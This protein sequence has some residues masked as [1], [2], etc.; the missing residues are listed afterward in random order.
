M[1]ESTT[2]TQIARSAWLGYFLTFNGQS[3]SYSTVY[4]P[5]FTSHFGIWQLHQTRI[6]TH[7]LKPSLYFKQ[8]ICCCCANFAKETLASQPLIVELIGFKRAIDEQSCHDTDNVASDASFRQIGIPIVLPYHVAMSSNTIHVAI[9]MLEGQSDI[10]LPAY[11]SEHAA[12][13]DVCAAVQETLSIEPGKIALVPAGFR[14]AVPI[15]YEAQIRPRSGLAV[16]QGI[17]MPNTPGTID[18]DYRGEVKVPLINH[19][20]EPFLVQR[21]MRI[22]QMIIKPVPRVQLEVVSKLDDTARGEGGFGHTGTHAQPT[23]N[24]TGSVSSM[25]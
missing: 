3:I 20:S 19:G 15:G 13:M 25:I 8:A 6:E 16:K 9:E 10:P 21:G 24:N 2:R 11:Q 18:A 12:G 23:A 14:M 17:S 5:S 22:A 1:T 4:A 7:G